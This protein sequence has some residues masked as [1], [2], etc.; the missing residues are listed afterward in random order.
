VITKPKGTK[1]IYGTEAKRWQY[2]SK[3]IDEVM[4]KYNYNFIRVPV[5]ESSE[6]FH[7]GVG[8]TSDIVT[9]ETYDFTDRGGRK[10]TLR[11]E[12][13][14]GVVRSYI[15]NKMYG[16]NNQPI[17]LY[18]NCPMYRYERP[19]AGRYRELTQFG[20][21]LIGSDD[22]LSDAEVISLAVNIYKILGLKGIKVNVNTLGDQESRDNYRKALIKHF[23]PHV[24]ELCEDCKERLEKNPLRILDCKVDQDK[25]VMKTAPKTVD[26]LNESS[27]ERFEKVKEYL[28]IMGV[29]YVVDPS[30]VRGLDYYNHT[31][32]EVEAKIEGFG[33]QNVIGGGGRYNTLVEQIGGPKTPGIGF[34]AGFDRL[35][36]ALE[37][38]KVNI[39]V[40]TS[41]DLFL[42]YVN[43]DE[44]KYAAYLTN[45]LRMNGFIVETDYLNR[46]LKAGF[47]Q[48][49]RVNSKFTIVLNSEDLK[50]NEVKIK[51]N[52][53]KEEDIISLDA[54]I[55]YLNENITEEDDCNCSASEDH[56]CNC[57][58]N[59]KCHKED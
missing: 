41:V 34:A 58:D 59:C 55:Y 23:K 28:G 31:V 36:L 46:S 16:D 3:V 18:Y 21:E 48:A 43:E 44:K 30:V 49:D 24:N 9:K 53:T 12:G 17:K 22:P 11:P 20:Y 14:A 5:F 1:D 56:N 7:R 38:E 54:I 27:K 52:K 29:E 33:A 25:E 47:K 37:Y 40:Q 45:E 15:E 50:Q 51:N 4:E 6:L 39:P 35:M 10:M 32:F 13:T 26:Y 8:E 19:Q 42:L 2:V 57:G